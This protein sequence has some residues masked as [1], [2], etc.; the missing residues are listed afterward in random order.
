MSG[1]LRHR[2]PDAA[3]GWLDPDAGIA[4]GHRRLSIIDLSENGAQPMVSRSGR[5]VISFN[6]EIYNFR[7]LRRDLEAQINVCGWR[8]HSDTEVLVEAIDH[9]GLAETLPRLNGM[10]AFAVWDRER[11]ELSL[12]RDAFGEKP[13]YY[14]WTLTA[15]LFGSELKALRRFPDFCQSAPKSRP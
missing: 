1:A 3:G 5:R 8:G 15:F 14:G 11:R 10:F 6:G 9:W 2:G 12:A 4:L 13:I 7:E